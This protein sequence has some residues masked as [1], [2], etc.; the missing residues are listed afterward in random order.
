[1]N[2]SNRLVDLGRKL[3]LGVQVIKLEDSSGVVGFHAGVV[4]HLPELKL[5][6]I[7][8][9]VYMWPMFSSGGL[10]VQ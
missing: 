10:M 2:I 3:S 9:V 4:L 1:M 7:Q 6:R 5:V 8:L